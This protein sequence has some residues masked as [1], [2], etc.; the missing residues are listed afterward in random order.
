MDLSSLN[1][2]RRLLGGEVYLFTSAWSRLSLFERL[3][4]TYLLPAP[5][6][7]LGSVGLCAAALALELSSGKVITCGLDFSFNLDSFHARSSPGHLEKLRRQNRFR[8]LLNGETAFRKGAFKTQAKNGEPVYS[9][10]SLQSYR[11]LFEQEFSALPVSQK[12]GGDQQ[13]LPQAGR[14]FDIAGTGLPLGIP[15]LSPEEAFA[16]LKS[17]A[18]DR[19]ALAIPTLPDKALL[20]DFIGKEREK[21]ALLKETLAGTSTASASLEELLDYCNYLWQH[22]PECAGTDGRRPSVQDISFLK[23]VRAEIDPFLRDFDISLQEL[24]N[25]PLPCLN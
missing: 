17:S 21:L 1:A 13:Q 7:P 10:P 14:L 24:E 4:A 23:R 11:D 3:N 2:H 19:P 15:V 18:P 20:R 25:E 6:P 12:N 22:F 9:D 5:I 16:L 8:S